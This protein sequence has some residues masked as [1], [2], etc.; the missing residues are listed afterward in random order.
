LWAIEG[1]DAL[2]QHLP[3][4]T[5]DPAIIVTGDITPFRERKVR[6]LNGTH[7]VM[8]PLSYLCGNDTVVA[9]MEDPLLSEFVRDVMLDEIVPS[10][11]ID[12]EEAADFARQVL[13]RFSNPFV[14]HELLNIAL[15]QTAKMDV[16]VAPSIV[17]GFTKRGD[18]P[19]RLVLGLAAFLVFTTGNL[20]AADAELPPDDRAEAIRIHWA[21]RVDVTGFVRAVLRDPSVWSHPLA[22]LQGLDAMLVNHVEA[23]L[24][25]GARQT[26]TDF[27]YA[28]NEQ[29]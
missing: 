2:R 16:R 7:S 8:A 6:I 4:R 24:R 13:E 1:D 19:P 11:D 9:S 18:L 25:D 27:L 5:D 15:H 29:R 28:T 3:V 23:I 12:V 10:L 17:S 21:H 20:R 22:E 26:L 14:S